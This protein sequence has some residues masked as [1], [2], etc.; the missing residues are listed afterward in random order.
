VSVVLQMESESDYLYQICL[1]VG[2]FNQ[3]LDNTISERIRVMA[4]SVNSSKVFGLKGKNQEQGMLTHLKQIFQD[5]G[6]AIK[7]VIIN[8]VVLP[9]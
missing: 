1:N 3:L 5:K 7:H 8:N 4:R 6:V 9:K 2:D